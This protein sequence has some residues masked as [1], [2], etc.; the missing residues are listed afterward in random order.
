MIQFNYLLNLV[1]PNGGHN[2]P[3]VVLSSGLRGGLVSNLVIS[4]SL[5]IIA[6]TVWFNWP[7]KGIKYK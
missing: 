2:V 1:D 5:G 6:L 7:Y 4:L 3:E